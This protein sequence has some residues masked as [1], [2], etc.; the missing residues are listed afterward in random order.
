MG[1]KIVTLCFLEIASWRNWGLLHGEP[2]VKN[3]LLLGA[4]VIPLSKAEWKDRRSHW[5][6]YTPITPTNLLHHSLPKN[7]LSSIRRYHF[8]AKI[9]RDFATGHQ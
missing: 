7:L 8:F 5:K 3:E 1:F 9:V 4:D 2:S 6:Y